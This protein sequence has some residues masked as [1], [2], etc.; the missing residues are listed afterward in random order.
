MPNFAANFSFLDPIGSR[1]ALSYTLRI[2]AILPEAIPSDKHVS[3][4]DLSTVSATPI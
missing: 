4:K 3:P 2:P 1:T